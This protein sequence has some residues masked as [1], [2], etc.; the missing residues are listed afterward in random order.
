MHRKALISAELE[1]LQQPVT[2]PLKAPEDK[3]PQFGAPRL[4]LCNSHVGLGFRV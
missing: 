4:G 1:T 2:P 3:E